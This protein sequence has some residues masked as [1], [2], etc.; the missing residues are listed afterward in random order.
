[1]QQHLLLFADITMLFRT[2]Q[3]KLANKHTTVYNTRVTFIVSSQYILSIEEVL[4]TY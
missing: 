4:E 2:T 3:N 1:M